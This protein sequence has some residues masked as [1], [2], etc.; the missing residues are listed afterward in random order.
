MSKNLVIVE[1]PAKAKTISRFLGDD[2]TVLASYGHVRDLPKSDIGIDIKRDFKPKY[3]ISKEKNHKAAVKKIKDAYK[4]GSTKIYIATD[5]D[6]EGEAIGWHLLEILKPKDKENTDRIVFHE[7]TK[8]AI[9]KALE[10]PRKLNIDLVNAQQAR[11]IL[12]RLVGYELSPLLWKKI[13]YGLSAGRVQSVAVKLIV[14]R[15]NEINAFD[16]EEYWS[17]EADLL[18]TKKEAFKT[19]VLKKKD[20]NIKITNEKDAKEITQILKKSDFTIENINAKN[21]KRN[22]A[23][24]FITST[25]QQEASRKLNFNV[26]QTMQVAQTLYEGV[27]VGQGTEGLITYMRTDSVNLSKEALS[28]CKSTIT[29]L[30]GKEYALENPRSYKSKKGAQEAHEAIRPV[31]IAYTP[32][33]IKKFL[34]TD[35]YKL[36]NLIWKRTLACQMAEAKLLNTSIDIKADEYLLRATGQQILFEGFMKVYIEGN[37]KVEE[38]NEQNILPI[39]KENEKLDLEKITPNQHFTKPPARYTEASLV[40]KMEELGIGRPSTYAPTISTIQSRGYITMEQKRLSPTDTANI[41]IKLLQT[42]FSDIMEYP[43]TAHME[44]KLDGIAE[45]KIDWVKML[46]EFYNPFHKNIVEKDKTISKKD[47]ISEEINK[48]CPECKKPL[49]KKLSRFGMFISCSGYPDCKYSERIGEDDLPKPK[50]LGKHPDTKEIIYAM[51]GRYGPYVK[52]GE[53]K[54]EEVTLK[55]G[56]TKMKKIKAKMVSIIPPY[57]LETIT[58]E[59]SLV[60]L[61]LPRTL[62]EENGIAIKA[63]NGRFG[64]YVQKDKEYRSIPKDGTLFTINLE[65]A[66]KLLAVPKAKSKRGATTLKE[67][68]EDKKSKKS[69]SIKSG[70]YGAYVTDGK[71]NASLPK[72]KT[73]EEFTLK[74]ALEL[75]ANKKNK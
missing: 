11:R 60:L 65:E 67:L 13:R 44:E 25:L 39:L 49:V 71:I 41:V 50:E 38:K 59:E 47:I 4:A 27:N 6:R 2:Y 9:L 23:P 10:N 52:L 63:N 34:N 43:F 22:P 1:S 53:D 26:R 51:T 20:K 28:Q 69:I 31:N 15:E 57:A 75:I 36:Y 70:R 58:L 37:D 7:I 17:I 62:G 61:T 21:T 46:R 5:E 48:K 68:G 45:G 12:D 64:P 54:E 33:S 35:Q 8:S 30:Y 74:E 18:N 32:E 19:K 40:K 73:P 42:H 66:L 56:K 29:K 72:G 14:E 24:S 55:S 16:T 3:Q